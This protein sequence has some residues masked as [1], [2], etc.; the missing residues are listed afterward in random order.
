MARCSDSADVS[1]KLESEACDAAWSEE[2]ERVPLKQRLKLL[3]ASK[4]LPQPGLDISAISEPAT[5]NVVRN[6]SNQCYSQ[7]EKVDILDVKQNGAGK[8]SYVKSYGV[9]FYE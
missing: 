2:H 3:L 4:R 5:T 6:H 7:E 8:S 9:R 1:I